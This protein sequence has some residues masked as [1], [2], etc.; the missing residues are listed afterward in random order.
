Q[1]GTP[2]PNEL[3]ASAWALVGGLCADR[4]DEAAAAFQRA[5]ATRRQLAAGPARPRDLAELAWFLATCPDERF[6]DAAGAV[7][8]ARAATERAPHD[9]RAWSRLGVALCRAGDWR[10]AAGA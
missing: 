4:P 5:L 10:A 3:L 1:P 2:A 9:G 6:R 8:A 7:A